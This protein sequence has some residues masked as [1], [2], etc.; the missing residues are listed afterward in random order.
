MNVSNTEN[1]EAGASV[2]HGLRSLSSHAIHCERVSPVSELKIENWKLLNARFTF[3]N[4]VTTI[5]GPV[6]SGKSSVLE[7]VFALFASAQFGIW[8]DYC[9][10]PV[11]NNKVSLGVRGAELDYSVS[12][13]SKGQ[14]GRAIGSNK[15]EVE[16]RGH[17][18]PVFFVPQDHGARSAR[19]DAFDWCFTWMKL[20]RGDYTQ[21]I[22][23]DFVA[24]RLQK[25][26]WLKLKKANEFE[27]GG[28]TFS[29]DGLSGGQ[30]D[31][32]LCLVAMHRAKK[33]KEKSLLMLDEPGQNLGAHERDLLRREMHRLINVQVITVTHHIEML[34][35]SKLPMGVVR[36]VRPGQRVYRKNDVIDATFAD[37]DSSIKKFLHESERA[38]FVSFIREPRNLSLFFADMLLLV[39]GSSDVRTV[40]AV[41]EMWI[42]EG[43][44]GLEC[45]VLECNGKDDCLWF[46]NIFR[47]LFE[48]MKLRTMLLLDLDV[49]TAPK[50][51]A[52]TASK[53][54]GKKK[55]DTKTA[56]GE[57]DE[58]ETDDENSKEQEKSDGGTRG[59]H[60]YYTIDHEPNIKNIWQ[61]L[62]PCIALAGVAQE[63]LDT[64][65][66]TAI[67]Q[68]C[69][70]CPGSWRELRV[71]SDLLASVCDNLLLFVKE[72]GSSADTVRS[73][74]LLSVYVTCL[75]I[76]FLADEN[77]PAFVWPPRVA[78]IEGVVFDKNWDFEI[79]P[80]IFGPRSIFGKRHTVSNKQDEMTI[81]IKESF[82]LSQSRIAC[83][84][85]AF[86]KAALNFPNKAERL[87]HLKDVFGY[88]QNSG[89]ISF[90]ERNNGIKDWLA[91]FSATDFDGFCKLLRKLKH[92]L[93]IS[94]IPRVIFDSSFPTGGNTKLH[95]AKCI[96]KGL[97][98]WC[99]KQMPQDFISAPAMALRKLC[100]QLND[101]QLHTIIQQ[102]LSYCKS[103][104]G[105]SSQ[106]SK[107]VA[108]NC[109]IEQLAVLFTA[110]LDPR[111]RLEQM[112]AIIG[113]PALKIEI[114]ESI[115]SL[116]NKNQVEI[117]QEFKSKVQSILRN[118]QADVKLVTN[119]G[120][121]IVN[122]TD[123]LLLYAVLSDHE[124]HPIGALFLKLYQM[125]AK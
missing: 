50:K 89:P 39:E 108:K 115:R 105:T 21:D 10:P 102:A 114:A 99:E 43:W 5:V 84:G 68:F 117:V 46:W 80:K 6:G 3:E 14:G 59:G 7:A 57:T 73:P 38:K 97:V 98:V 122:V 103:S 37:L 35:R 107:D 92:T 33:T 41:D 86:V 18:P 116:R 125:Q 48:A 34:D 87:A 32:I 85:F 2:Y 17:V 40:R 123:N 83:D 67:E 69:K 31:A 66:K 45:C 81:D 47:K 63:Q 119:E 53:K 112:Q 70:R 118:I 91:K 104:S 94:D 15:F 74:D 11:T 54:I 22:M 4:D 120:K 25:I 76:L 75:N 23:T 113:D 24:A 124:I 101:Y 82:Y 60:A 90:S 13:V 65:P 61:L 8:V 62:Q 27:M 16:R 28:S 56:Q 36:F 64:N 78:D 93:A 71:S 51:K 55:A 30:V 96:A 44:S 9:T 77:F 12:L 49:L 106:S 121:R 52:V 19:Y 1:A 111:S 20:K 58:G 100:S 42:E 110:P 88:A 95:L 26:C 109:R 72:I 29:Y 79:D